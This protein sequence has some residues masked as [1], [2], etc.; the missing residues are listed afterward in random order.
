MIRYIW[1]IDIDYEGNFEQASVLKLEI[2]D[3]LAINKTNYWPN[4]CFKWVF[5]NGDVL[6]VTPLFVTKKEATT[7]MD[8]ELQN[9]IYDKC[10]EINIIKSYI[11]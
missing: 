7:Y 9:L 6:W 10:E 3:W 4:Y 8:C 11:T 1:K 5:V 2:K